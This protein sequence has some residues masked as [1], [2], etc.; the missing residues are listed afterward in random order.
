MNALCESWAQSLP[1]FRYIPVVS[2]ALAEDNWTGRTGF[3]HRAV[4]E[5]CPDLSAHQVYACGAPVVI[6][7]AQKDFTSQCQLPVEE[8]Y[9]DAFTSAADLADTV[10]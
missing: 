1:N 4:M 7:A 10:A 5:D 8:F 3:V 6:D 2:D 9:A